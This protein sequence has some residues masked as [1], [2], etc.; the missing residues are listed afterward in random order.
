MVIIAK[1]V[2]CNGRRFQGYEHFVKV[3]NGD[4]LLYYMHDG[5]ETLATA[6]P[7]RAVFS[8]G[9]EY[10][11]YGD[12]WEALPHFGDGI[13]DPADVAE[14]EELANKAVN[15]PVHYVDELDHFEVLDI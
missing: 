7:T 1:K 4:I 8:N 9:R 5:S 11:C 15:V 3:T 14:I 6:K 2:K 13:T 10:T 12:T